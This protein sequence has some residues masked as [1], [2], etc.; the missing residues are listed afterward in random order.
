MWTR[1][2]IMMTWN[3]LCYNLVSSLL[4]MFAN[5]I[6]VQNGLCFA[7]VGAKITWKNQSNERVTKHAKVAM[8]VELFFEYRPKFINKLC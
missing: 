8:A 1:K 5:G 7:V 3:R 4:N 6:S 2:N